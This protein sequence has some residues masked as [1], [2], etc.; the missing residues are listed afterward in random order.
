MIEP[1]EARVVI[2]R[3][4]AVQEQLAVLLVDAL[5]L[6]QSPEEID[7]DCPLFGTGLGLDSIDAVELVVA[8]E[9]SF[10]VRF[11]DAPNLR[12]M[13]TANSLVDFILGEQTA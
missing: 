1:H 9:A 13:R 5:R 3:R 2:E 12:P 11:P 8:V 4:R 10:G 6:D 7:P